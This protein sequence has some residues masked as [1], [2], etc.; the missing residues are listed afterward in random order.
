MEREIAE[1]CERVSG[2]EDQLS[3]QRRR[4]EGLRSVSKP[5]S[6]AERAKYKELME[7]LAAGRDESYIRGKLS[8]IRDLA[9]GSP[10]RTERLKELEALEKGLE[11][12]LLPATAQPGD[13]AALGAHLKDNLRKAVLLD[14]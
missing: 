14:V 5:V 13:S 9:A 2:L 7:G 8:E 11:G 1:V 12:V 6:E 10:D 4:L 3:L